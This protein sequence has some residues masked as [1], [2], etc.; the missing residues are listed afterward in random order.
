MHEGMNW[1]VIDPFTLRPGISL[2]CVRHLSQWLSEGEIE[3]LLCSIS[4]IR[5]VSLVFY[6]EEQR[7]GSQ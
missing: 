3:A 7:G 2:E 6:L 1:L 4:P 5:L